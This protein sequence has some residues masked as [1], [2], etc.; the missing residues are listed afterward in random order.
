MLSI[1][2]VS[3]WLDL[4]RHKYECVLK[5]SFTLTRLKIS[6][7]GDIAELPL[8]SNSTQ[9]HDNLF[10][11]IMVYYSLKP[12]ELYR[13]SIKAHSHFCHFFGP[14]PTSRDLRIRAILWDILHSWHVNNFKSSISFLQLRIFIPESN[15]IAFS[16]QYCRNK[17]WK[18]LSCFLIYSSA[19]AGLFLKYIYSSSFRSPILNQ[20][21]T[22]ANIFLLWGLL[23]KEIHLYGRKSSL[24][25]R[26]GNL[27]L[28]WN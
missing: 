22:W 13:N 9:E 25:C 10:R 27:L 7:I 18:C 28:P 11:I 2:T 14:V 19:R 23:S 6:K 15:L 21:C 3:D 5:A 1:L 4:P 8:F 20:S 24:L 26:R 12:A 16:A 17:Y